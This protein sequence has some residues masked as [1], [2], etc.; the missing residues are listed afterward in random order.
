M[1]SKLSVP[2]LVQHLKDSDQDFEWYPTTKEI[3]TCVKLDARKVL[4]V[5]RDRD[6]FSV[7]DCGAGD[8]RVLRELT[9]GDR[10]AIEKSEIHLMAIDHEI[11]I[12]G[13]DFHEQSLIDKKVDVLFSNPPYSEFEAWAVKIIREANAQ[14]VYLVIPTRWKDSLDIQDAVKARQCEAKI[15]SSFDFANAERKA[16][17]TVDVIR[18]QLSGDYHGETLNTDP[19]DVWFES[20]F[21]LRKEP[22]EEDSEDAS[23]FKPGQSTKADRI[24][25]K[26][27]NALVPGSDYVQ[28][29]ENLYNDDMHSLFTNYRHFEQMDADLLR[30]VGVTA[31]TVKNSLRQ[32]IDGLKHVYWEIFFSTFDRITSKLISERR[33]YMLDKIMRHVNI[34]FTCS[35]AY[36]IAVWA[37]KNANEYFD[38]Q[39][40]TVYERMIT[41]ANIQN[42]AS[43]KRTFGA[44]EWRYSR[45]EMRETI[46]RIK[47]DYRVVLEWAGGVGSFNYS[48]EGERYNGLSNETGVE[49]IRDLRTIA[50]NLGF[51]VAQYPYEDPLRTS[52]WEPGKPKLFHAVHRGKQVELMEVKGF[53]NRNF[54]IKF[55]QDFLI[56]LNVEFGRI[57]GWLRNKE[58]AASE[59]QVTP[60][61]AASAFATNIRLAGNPQLLLGFNNAEAV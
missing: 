24:K 34:D 20:A 19:F 29:L 39:L 50:D 51:L 27:R 23:T 10:Y 55:N 58:E 40:V 11:S 57:K 15:L 52:R 26:A 22:S 28:V 43:N 5:R 1:G 46:E 12:A 54:H 38:R 44:E 59:L 3:I 7:L 18:L 21:D 33:K 61:Q 53:K 2:A 17:A 49:Y 35:N 60:E 6:G 36:A 8:G 31:E 4:S 42:Y 9:D 45:R 16:R 13:T 41:Q 47:L 48:F 30:E 25:T 56:K 32:R 14:V 37:I